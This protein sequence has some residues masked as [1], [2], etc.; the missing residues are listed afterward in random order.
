LQKTKGEGL[1]LAF[2]G[3]A[4][5]SLFG[6][7]AGNVL[8]KGTAILAVAFVVCTLALGVMFSNSTGGSSLMSEVPSEAVP[9]PQQGMPQQGMPMQQTVPAALPADT[10]DGGTAPAPVAPVASP[11]DAAPAAE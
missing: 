4:G 11:A 8:T 1:G 10:M 7:R 5:E 3:G 6:S 2:G 9:A